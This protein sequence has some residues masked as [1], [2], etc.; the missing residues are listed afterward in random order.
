MQLGPLA[1][2]AAPVDAALADLT[3]PASADRTRETTTPATRSQRTNVCHTICCRDVGGQWTSCHER[4]GADDQG[5]GGNDAEDAEPLREKVVRRRAGQQQSD[6]RGQD[7]GGHERQLEECLTDGRVLVGGEVG[8]PRVHQRTAE[9][10]G[11]DERS[12]AEHDGSGASLAELGEHTDEHDEGHGG[13][14]QRWNKDEDVG[15]V[16]REPRHAIWAAL[17]RVSGVSPSEPIPVKNRMPAATP[18]S[19]ARFASR[20]PGGRELI[21]TGS[22]RLGDVGRSGHGLQ[23]SP[24]G[25]V[26]F[27]PPVLVNT[28]IHGAS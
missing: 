20:A 1:C 9:D 27:D 25:F 11:G 21:P 7:R 16:K 24:V 2:Q 12:G 28:T 22:S 6:R 8:Q 10:G 4:E 19:G 18:S 23:G 14:R 5:R 3:V 26:I 17:S 13:E 15:A